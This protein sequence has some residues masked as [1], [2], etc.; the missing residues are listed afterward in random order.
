ML[1]ENF[2]TNNTRSEIQIFQFFFF[3][4]KYKE[5]GHKN[6]IIHSEVSENMNDV[7]ILNLRLTKLLMNP[8]LSIE[9]LIIKFIFLIDGKIT[10]TGGK[11]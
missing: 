4:R 7:V 3:Y 6:N 8:K 2:L 10:K 5:I 9:T 11:R 1:S